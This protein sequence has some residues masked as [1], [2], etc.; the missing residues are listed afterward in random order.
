MRMKIQQ[1]EF[2]IKANVVLNNP[3]SEILKVLKPFRPYIEKRQ[4][5]LS[6]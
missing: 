1:G 4:F 5:K 3:E 2:N 6:L